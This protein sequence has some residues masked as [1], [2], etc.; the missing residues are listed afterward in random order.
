M[1]YILEMV[2]LIHTAGHKSGTGGVIT[3]SGF[4]VPNDDNDI[5]P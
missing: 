3:T 1:T 4:K 2:F 5:F